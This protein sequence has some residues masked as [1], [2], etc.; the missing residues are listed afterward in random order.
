[1]QCR[2]VEPQRV[3]GRVQ[4][5]SD[6]FEYR[7][8]SITTMSTKIFLYVCK[9]FLLSHESVAHL[10]SR[11]TDSYSKGDDAEIKASN[12]LFNVPLQIEGIFYNKYIK[13]S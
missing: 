9:H 12:I 6:L 1:M 4:T 8:E 11:S 2:R 13:I 7:I 5:L 3:Q 10:V